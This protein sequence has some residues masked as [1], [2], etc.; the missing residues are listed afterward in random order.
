MNL[1]IF[2]T[3]PRAEIG[4]ALEEFEAQFR[5][6]LGGEQSFSISHGRDYITFF[7]AI[8]APTLVVAEHRGRILGTLSAA[9]RALRFPDGEKRT[10]AYLGDLK[11]APSARGGVVL[12]RMMETLHGELAVPA[13]GMAYGVVMDGTGRVP[14]SYTG[15]I[16]VPAF[17]KTGRLC[18]LKATTS[19]FA[20]RASTMSEITAD[21]WL[22]MSDRIVLDGFL[23]IG[24]NP[25]LRSE[26]T[27]QFL[28]NES[29]STVGRI[30]DT[31]RA[32]RLFIS[33]DHE[34]RAAHLTGFTFTS[35]AE[36]AELFKH[37]A[38]L[39]A[40]RGIPTLFA[41]VPQS[42]A[43]MFRAVLENEIVQFV[44]ATVFGC[45]FNEDEADWWVDTAEI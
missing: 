7:A 9:L 10:V 6:P 21:E 29:G 2:H 31:Q 8:G 39:C 36:G 12:A 20:N 18:I 33:P 3:P 25:L 23:P 1:R 13:N 43:H 30:E 11:I 14:P 15:R 34:I 24:G 5:Y 22:R 42:A 44:P 27:P 41:A 35:A 17:S 38:A 45:G 32:K 26:M 40:Q 37:A 28:A 19:G 16:G 4:A